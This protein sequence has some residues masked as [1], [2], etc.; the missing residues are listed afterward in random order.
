MRG[1]HFVYIRKLNNITNMRGRIDAVSHETRSAPSPAPPPC[2]DHLIMYCD[3]VLPYL[4]SAVARLRVIHL[5]RLEMLHIVCHHNSRVIEK[6]L[7]VIKINNINYVQTKYFYFASFYNVSIK[8]MRIMR[9]S[10]TGRIES[11]EICSSIIM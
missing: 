11:V 9:N 8:A 5:S 1:S 7:I 2:Q 10:I 4:L 3:F 6:S